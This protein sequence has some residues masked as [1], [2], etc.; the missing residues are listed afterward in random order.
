MVHKYI[1]RKWTDH[2]QS[3]EY[4]S[5][6][7]EYIKLEIFSF[8]P[9]HTKSYVAEYNTLVGE[10]CNKLNFESL[11]VF[12]SQDKVN[13]MEFTLNYKVTENGAYRIDILYIKDPTMYN[14][15]TDKVY[16]TSK[17]LTGWYDIYK[18]NTKSE[19][20]AQV[21]T[22]LP[23]N[24][25]KSVQKAFEKTRDAQIKIANNSNTDRADTSVLLKFEGENNALKRKTVFKDLDTGDWKF[26]FGV[27]HNCYVVGAII[28]KQIT[29][30]GTN[31]DEPGTNLQFTDASLTNSEMGKAKELQCT[32]GYDDSF[33]CDL[34]RSGLYMTYMD[35][36][37]LYVKDNED[38]IVQVFGGYVST[39]VPNADIRKITIHA[40]DRLKDGENKYIL[41]QL[42]IQNGGG[43]EVSHS[44]D[45]SIHFNRYSDV[46]KYLCRLY[47]C[48][49]KNNIT[50]NF[51][52]DVE[53]Y[54]NTF[55]IGYG[56]K[57]D[58]K[59]VSVTNGIVTV[60]N[61]SVTLRNNPSSAKKQV[62]T[63]YS[64]K[65]PINL[66]NYG[67]E[68]RP[69][70][71]HITYGLGDV[72][73][74]HKVKDTIA[75]DNTGVAGSQKFSKCG[76]SQDGKYIMAIGQRSV[77]RG[78]KTYPYNQIYKTVFE[79]KCPH[80]G[81][82]LVW[83]SGRKDTDCVHCGHYKHSK[84]EWGNISET[85]I[86]CSKCC[87]DFCS[88][89]G[90]DKDGKYSKKLTKV[91]S[92]VKSSKAEQNKLHNGE[93]EGLPSKKVTISADD[94]FKAIKNASKGW[95]HSTGTGTTASYLEK[96]GVGDCWAWSDWISKQLKKYKVNHK[97][98]EYK[99]SGS[100]QHRSVLYQNSKG[101]YVDFPYRKYGFPQGTYNTK[102]SSNG[103]KIKGYSFGGRINQAVATSGGKTQTTEVTVTNGYDKDNPFQAYLDITFTLGT[104]K[105]K[106]HVY[107][108]FTQQSTSN[109]SISGLKPVWVNNSSQEI[110]LKG[111]LNKI[112][113]Y[114]NSTADVYL[115]SL[116][117]V[118]PKVKS[119]QGDKNN[120]WYTND[121]NTKDNSS[122]KMILYSISF[123]N[124]DG[125]EPQDLKACGESINT[126]IK[127][128]I[129][130]AN[131]IMSMDYAEHR[132]DDRI[133]FNIASNNNAVFTATEGDKNNIL[134][135]G[136]ISFDPA[137]ELFN[138]SRCVLK[139]RNTNLYSYVG[140]KDIESILRFQEQCTLL[141][142][143]E[144]IGAKEAYWNA[145][146]NEKFNSDITYNY[147]ITV[148]G[149][150]D[151]HLKDL[152]E[153]IS[154]AKRLNTLK[155]V[156]SI[157]L[158]YDTG[159]KPVI[160]TELG[161][162]ELAPDLQVRQTIK[163]L[164]DS[165]KS[166]TTYFYKSATPVNDTEVYEWEY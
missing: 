137:N 75:A 13:P 9:V 5:D 63:V 106:R 38:N 160:Q 89:T 120:Q 117:F 56:K 139:Q 95:K 32:V 118:T 133:N 36:C 76:R 83:D 16:N 116:A 30:W 103:K 41:D 49:L 35:E 88:V 47:E 141:T 107:V 24:A 72:K 23:K 161:L 121:K 115:H 46:L 85:E 11:V 150:P 53:K 155:E 19:H 142:E 14:S 151:L 78:K 129:D 34:N 29:F 70:N 122:C 54:Q 21:L 87:A 152:V 74:D 86:T 1:K 101:N 157:T 26:E 162:G 90:W 51:K 102:G 59:K 37:N 105:K 39:P 134:D 158:K 148:R 67:S 17:D 94:I 10:N 136:N 154:D 4:L 146:H 71:L 84:R 79:N 8:D 113:D 124:Q 96:H 138:V 18:A 57:R 104:N 111:I 130:D 143:N 93:M 149:Y 131:Y 77:G 82:K 55:M 145:R 156:D 127:K 44:E 3:T 62:F 98:V 110:T 135:W 97:V 52:V 27:P 81:G 50:S 147:T 6:E 2:A 73:T 43:E 165:A 114:Y 91:G 40:A 66:S 7:D 65:K 64:T 25:S 31:N 99:S 140:T 28:R 58:V 100:N 80:C 128:V 45:N 60:N 164:R 22:A 159:T 20:K 92:S 69:V 144:A 42:W 126:V 112:H 123:D 15:A 119:K 61:N 12:Q 68:E 132:C 48:T 125:T 33:E 166:E 153:V 163:K 108:D 109:Y